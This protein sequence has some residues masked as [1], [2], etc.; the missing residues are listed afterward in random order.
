[1]PSTAVAESAIRPGRLSPT[2]PVL[3]PP[4]R[5]LRQ[6]DLF[7]VITF[8]CVI[9]QHSILWPVTSSSVAGWGLVMLLH[10][11][12]NA[13][14]F[15]SAVVAAYAQATRPRSTLALWYRRLS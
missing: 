8:V 12:R 1:V 4:G 15:L 6:Y 7:R 3:Q 14:F 5:Y 10:Y 2:A 11:T 9:G 13:F